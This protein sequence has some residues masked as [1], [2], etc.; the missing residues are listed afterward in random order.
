M[1]IAS[2]RPSIIIEIF[3]SIQTI[4]CGKGNLYI[5]FVHIDTV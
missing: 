3:M 2:K 4:H 5:V 1:F